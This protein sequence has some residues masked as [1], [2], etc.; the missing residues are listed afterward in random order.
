MKRISVIGKYDVYQLEKEMARAHITKLT[1]LINTIPLV[2]YSEEDIIAESKRERVFYG[3]WE[4]SLVVFDG[5]NPIALVIGYERKKE[6]NDQYPKN[7]L[8]I[9]ELAVDDAYHRQGIAHELLKV[10]FKF[11]QSF[12]FLEGDFLFTLQ[13][14][15]AEWN[16]HVIDLYA[17]FGFKQTAV[18]K[19]ENRVDFILCMKPVL[20]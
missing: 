11:N 5:T 9:S 2:E 13:T 3:K 4:H 12:S 10:F 16:R 8:Y 19:Y 1:Q 15:S 7:S 18:K 17:S 20:H 6:G 14:N